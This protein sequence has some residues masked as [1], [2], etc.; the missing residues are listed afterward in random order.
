MKAHQQRIW[1]SDLR[2][3]HNRNTLAVFGDSFTMA[4]NAIIGGT[5]FYNGHR[6]EY[7]NE[8]SS[9]EWKH[10]HQGRV[11]AFDDTADIFQLY[12]NNWMTHTAMRLDYDFQSYGLGGSN[13]Y[14]AYYSMLEYLKHT[15]KSPEVVILLVNSVHRIYHPDVPNICPGSMDMALQEMESGQFDRGDRVANIF[16]STQLY[17]KHIY[18]HEH[19]Q[20]RKLHFCYYLDNHIVPQYPD[21]KFVIISGFPDNPVEDYCDPTEFIYRYNYKNCMDIR[22]PMMHLTKLDEKAGIAP[23]DPIFNHLSKNAALWFGKFMAEQVA[24]WAPEP[25]YYN[26]TVE[27]LQEYQQLTDAEKHQ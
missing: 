7:P 6:E 2:H 17:Y 1:M 9:N 8:Y 12:T 26:L 14:Y 25:R 23:T 5:H 22:P 18:Y 27:D 15:P 10:Q 11:I 20:I 21:T 24:T 4:N 3:N 13:T 16:K 19:E